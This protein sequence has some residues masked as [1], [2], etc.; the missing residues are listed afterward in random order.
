M[1]SPGNQRQPMQEQMTLANVRQ[2]MEQNV[3]DLRRRELI[4]I[5]RNDETRGK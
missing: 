4:E 3:T 5:L 1:E 2:F